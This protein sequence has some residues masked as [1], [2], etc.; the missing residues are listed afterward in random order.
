M[1]NTH[2]EEERSIHKVL[3]WYVLFTEPHK[4]HL[5]QELLHRRGLETYLPLTR[6]ARPRK[7]RRAYLP[8]FPRYLFVR[9]DL[10]TV[11]RSALQWLPGVTYLVCFGGEPAVVPDAAVAFLRERLE[12][13]REESLGGFRPGDRVR[14]RSGPLMGLEAVF[15]KGLS[16]A[17][18]VRVL[19]DFLGRQRSCEVDV[20][21]LEPVRA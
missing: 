7:G 21:C 18:R 14:F 19:L 10:G 2:G 17:G 16:P 11:G 6:A 5:V 12:A 15:Q 20:D 8:F 4:E 3:R 9:A 13:V 1:R